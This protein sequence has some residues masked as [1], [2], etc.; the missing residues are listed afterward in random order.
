M[1]TKSKVRKHRMT[2]VSTSGW[3]SDS[4]FCADITIRIGNKHKGFGMSHDGFPPDLAIDHAR[5][6]AFLEAA[7]NAGVDVG[8]TMT[9]N[10]TSFKV[11]S[12][13]K[14]RIKYFI[15]FDKKSVKESALIEMNHKQN[16]KRARE[17]RNVDRYRRS[18]IRK[19]SHPDWRYLDQH[20]AE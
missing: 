17:E 8:D 20:N 6:K 1:T 11:A 5:I 14:K 13:N 3:R 19:S 10:K 15:A 12:L 18:L 16:P 7:K 2:I 4:V 9:R